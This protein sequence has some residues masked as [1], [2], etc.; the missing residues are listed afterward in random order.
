MLSKCGYRTHLSTC[1]STIAFNLALPF[2]YCDGL[3]LQPSP[4][5][6]EDNVL[7]WT[8]QTSVL[9][10]AEPKPKGARV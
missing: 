2:Q 10:E 4:K 5:K 1:K 8:R 6:N 7:D 9:N 3:V